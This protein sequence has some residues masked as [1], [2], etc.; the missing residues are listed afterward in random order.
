MKPMEIEKK[1]RNEYWF[2]LVGIR[3]IE[4]PWRDAAGVKDP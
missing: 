3:K 4:N 2:S 1:L